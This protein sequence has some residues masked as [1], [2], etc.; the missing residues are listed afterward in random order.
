MR[1]RLVGGRWDGHAHP[2]QT[3]SQLTPD[4]PSRPVAPRVSHSML[5]LST[6]H[7][8]CSLLVFLKSLGAF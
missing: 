3:F 5:I 6:T 7:Q 1:G 2:S 8:C 4:L